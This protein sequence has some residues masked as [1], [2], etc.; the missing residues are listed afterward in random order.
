M[1]GPELLVRDGG[2]S[3]GQLEA[4]EPQLTDPRR[5]EGRTRTSATHTAHISSTAMCS[6]SASKTTDAS[7]STMAGPPQ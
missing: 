1:S 3:A 6:T 4:V 2:E 7:P 5:A